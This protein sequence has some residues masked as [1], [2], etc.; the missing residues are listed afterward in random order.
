MKKANAVVFLTAALA[1][2]PSP[3]L[4]AAEYPAKPITVIVAYA[5]GGETDIGARIVC[6]M[7]E[8][9]LG[10]PL[11]VVNKGGAGGQ[12]GW[13]EL[14]RQKPDGYTIGFV[15]PPG[16]N[17]VIIDPER[18]A[19][20]TLDSFTPII[21]QVVDPVCFYVKPESRYKTFEDILEDAKKRPS[22]ITMTTTGI[23]SNE[24]LAILMLQEAAKVKFRIVHFDGSAPLLTALMG[25]QVDVGVDN[26]GGAW[27]QRVKAGQIRPLVV[28]DREKSKFYPGVPTTV[29]KGYPNLI[30]SSSRGIVGPAG[31]PQ[32]VVKKLETVF[33]KAME[34]PD[35]IEKMDKAGLAVKVLVG[36]EYGKY[37]R[38]LH[39]T[40]KRLM[41]SVRKAE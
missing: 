10:Q 25:G 21:N 24:H 31:M 5:A 11:I 37:I 22:Q 26:V 14:A 1:L 12:I 33:K 17:S 30:M 4:W 20:F 27:T 35:H 2:I 34:S 3:L 7:A 36:D 16:L 18:K 28:F 40:T 38:E 8:K 19:T 23:F 15:N 13:T 39:E 41:E 6:S 29:E 32:P 9:D